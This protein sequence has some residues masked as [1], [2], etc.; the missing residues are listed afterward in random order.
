VV[1]D[2]LAHVVGAA[3][4]VARHTVD[5]DVVPVLVLSAHV[6]QLGAEALPE[7]LDVVGVADPRQQAQQVG[8]VTAL[9]LDLGDLGRGEQAGGWLSSGFTLVPEAPTVTASAR[10]PTFSFSVPIERR[11]DTLRMLCRRSKVWKPVSS[12]L[13]VYGPTL[14]N[15]NSPRPSVT[16][17]RDR[18]VAFPL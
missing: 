2:L 5:R 16:R 10:P 8:D 18:W 14:T 12:T 11:S 4:L 1:V 9:G 3:D 13:T 7:R 6:G 17:L 15:R